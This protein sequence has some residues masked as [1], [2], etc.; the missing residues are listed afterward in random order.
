MRDLPRR[1]WVFLAVVGMA[2]GLLIRLL[3]RSHGGIPTWPV[4]NFGVLFFLAELFPVKMRDASYSVSY[5][6]GVAA[7]VALGPAAAATVASFGGG[8]SFFMHTWKDWPS[9]VGFNSFQLALST[10]VSGVGYVWAGGPVGALSAHDF[11]RVLFAL[12][13]ASVLFFVVNAMLVATMISM[14]RGKRLVEVLHANYAAIMGKTLAF[15]L[16]GLFLG[17]LYFELGIW[18]PLFVLVPLLVARRALQS[19]ARMGEAYEATLSS[20]VT[21]IEAKDAYTRGHA[22]RVSK[23]TTLIARELGFNEKQIH[24]IRIAALM[25]DVGKLVVSTAILTKPGKLTDE[26]YEHM[27]WHPIFGCEVIE[28]IDFLRE[29]EAVNAVRHHHERL[30]GRGYPDNLFGDDVPITARVVMVADAF[31]SMTSTRTYRFARSVDDGLRELRRCAATQFDPLCIAA[32]ARAVEK[33]GWEPTPEL[34][35]GE[36]TERPAV[37]VHAQHA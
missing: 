22:E 8:A 13:V 14:V 33:H 26:E 9:R 3:S 37:S 6:I 7:L 31:D 11:P 30:D 18:A 4:L 25:H 34:Y 12:A 19:T 29:G 21:A 16:V 17:A 20:L 23:L 15:G 28:E 10:S 36:K 27:K 1:A 32:L 24:S 2:A 35:E 5:V